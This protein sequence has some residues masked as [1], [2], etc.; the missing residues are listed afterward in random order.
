MLHYSLAVTR[1]P[2]SLNSG[3]R[4]LAGLIITWARK[5]RGTSNTQI[6]HVP[7]YP[8]RHQ[9]FSFPHDVITPSYLQLDHLVAVRSQRDDVH[10]SQLHAVQRRCELQHVTAAVLGRPLT[11]VTQIRQRFNY[12]YWRGKQQRRQKPRIASPHSDGQRRQQGAL[13]TTQNSLRGL[14]V[15]IPRT[16]DTM[17]L[18]SRGFQ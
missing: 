15:Y 2:I 9:T 6:K 5:G 13:S 3:A 8:P 4:T 12:G 14:G 18:P 1:L 16:M 17:A 10:A 11:H 7:H